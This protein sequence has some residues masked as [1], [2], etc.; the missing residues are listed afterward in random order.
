MIQTLD[1]INCEQDGLSYE[2][3]ICQH[4]FDNP[5]QTWFSRELSTENPWPDAGCSECDL[6][7]ARDSEW[8]ETNSGSIGIKLLCYLCY[9]RGRAQATSFL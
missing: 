8:T 3:W 2:T 4:L 7:F 6:V 1:K 5:K 9:E